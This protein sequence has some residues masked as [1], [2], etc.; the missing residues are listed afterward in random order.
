MGWQRGT[1]AAGD[2]GS[3]RGA[4]LP[5]AVV[6]DLVA[7]AKRGDGEAFGRLYDHYVGEVYAFV[8]VRL[9]DQE[10]AQDM[11]QSIFVRALQSLASCQED[12]AFPGWLFAIARN[13]VT[14]HFRA[15]RYRPIALEE[16]FERTDP[17][18][19]PEE[20]AVQRDDARVL[21]EA[22]ERCLSASEREL[23]DLILTGLNDKQIGVALGR[24]HGAIRVAHHRLMIKLRDCLQ[25][26][27]LFA[28]VRRASL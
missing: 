13:S 10:A 7:R 5:S 28:E 19:T 18:L 16:T 21:R 24:S 26:L 17:D 22:R 25:R 6:A 23:F 1:P 27:N 2:E 9:L 11:T 12:A 14:D 8:A 15:A 4:R 20:L 3:P